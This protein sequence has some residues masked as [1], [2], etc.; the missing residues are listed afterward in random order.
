MLTVIKLIFS[1]AL[2][3]FVNEIVVTRSK[4]LLG[5]MIASLPLV[6]IITFFWIWTGLKESPAEQVEKLASHSTGV[7]WFVLP[8]LPMFL[9][10]PAL[11]RKGLSFLPSILICCVITMLLY[12]GMVMILKRFG[13]EL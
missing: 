13:M 12:A 11:L 7:F 2:I 3:Y 1:A 9:I 5:S 6:S 8:S 10:F 4:P